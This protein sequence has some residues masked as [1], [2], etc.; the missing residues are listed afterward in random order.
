MVEYVHSP[1]DEAFTQ[2]HNSNDSN[3]SKGDKDEVFYITSKDKEP[4]QGHRF[5][6]IEKWTG[7]EDK[8]VKC[9]LRGHL[10]VK[11]SFWKYEKFL[12]VL[13][14]EP[15]LYFYSISD[16]TL[17]ERVELDTLV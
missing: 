3:N 6:M 13:S 10:K 7:Y 12:T 11:Q 4:M 5:S 14:S 8:Y 2:A 17:L 9:M 16:Y 15:A 1:L